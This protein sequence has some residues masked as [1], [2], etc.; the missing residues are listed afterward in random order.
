MSARKADIWLLI[1]LWA[2]LW[3]GEVLGPWW[4]AGLIITASL[5]TLYFLGDVI[6]LDEKDKK[7]EERRSKE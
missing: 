2:T 4:K 3:L 7:K 6:G 5:G 1:M